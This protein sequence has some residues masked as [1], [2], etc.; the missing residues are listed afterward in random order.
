M[1]I[2]VVALIIFREVQL[3]AARP[4]L[5]LPS[6]M[7]KPSLSMS[8]QRTKDAKRE[9]RALGINNI[10]HKTAEVRSLTIQECKIKKIGKLK[11]QNPQT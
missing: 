2:N 3:M 10:R 8:A 9:E 6:S 5:V 4:D 7:K 1:H 11:V